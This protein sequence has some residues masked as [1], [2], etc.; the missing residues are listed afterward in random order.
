[1]RDSDKNAWWRAAEVLLGVAVVALP[2]ALGGAPW[3]TLFLL[4]PLSAAAVGVWSWGAFRKK[5][6]WSW[7]PVLLLP[8]ATVAMAALQLIPLPPGLLAVL[9]PPA[10]EVRDFALLPL[11]LE[12]W[13]PITLDAASTWRM[14]ARD[15]SLGGLLFVAVQLGRLGPSRERLLSIVGATAIGFA[16]IAVVHQLAG[17]DELFG[18]WNFRTANPLLTPFGNANHLAAFLTLGGTVCLG[19]ALS[20]PERESLVGWGLGA[21]GCG[22][23]VFLT[24][25]RGG[26]G[27]FL[28][29]WLLVAG[30]VLA[31]R[32]G[33]VKS[34]APWLIIGATIVGAGLLAWEQLLARADTISSVAKLQSSKLEEWP[35]FARAVAAGGRTGLGRGAFEV[36][37]SR[38][39]EFQMSVTFTH[40]ENLALQLGADFGVP[41]ALAL[42]GLAAW[43]LWRAFRGT[44][45]SALEGIAL[46]GVVG[47][48]L[49]DLFDFSLE[50]NALPVVAAVVLGLVA[51]MDDQQPRATVRLGESAV[52]SGLV[53]MGVGA[54]FLGFPTHLDDEGRLQQAIAAGKKAPELRALVV[55]LLRRHP[56]DYLLYAN[57]AQSSAVRG[58][59]QNALAWVNRWQ[60]LRPADPQAHVA[61]AHALLRLGRREQALLE[62]KTSFLFGDYSAV[63]QAVRVAA[64]KGDYERLFVESR[65]L[66]TYAVGTLGGLPNANAVA[67]GLVE[68]ALA[69]PPSDA[70]K[71]EAMEL[72]LS[73]EA[74]AGRASEALAL[75]DALPE[76][77]RSRPDMVVLKARLL[78]GSGRVEEG[79][80]VLAGVLT[81][82][83]G[84]AAAA[85]QLAELEAGRGQPQAALDVLAR[86]KPFVADPA[87]R[88]ALFTREAT[89]W[90]STGRWA[91]ALDGWQTASRLEPARADLH[92]RM[93]AA[94]ERMGSM[95]A[96]LDEVRAGR[97]L[98]TPEGAK[99]QDGWVN[100][101]D[102]QATNQMP[103]PSPSPEP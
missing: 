86:I 56:A 4:V 3:W 61:A 28:L 62:Y 27:S 15:L 96:A 35:M 12:A 60:F 14:L 51:G 16:I 74:N 11:G 33:G 32:V 85:F 76:D 10:A 83:P 5:R 13:R 103:V 9:A 46:L 67:Q 44:R 7:H 22:V 72:K 50:L 59:A 99:A 97:L 43:A 81:Q 36:A 38:W 45:G 66:L 102:A 6:R 2:V 71:W 70:V 77:V 65:G 48:G 30:L 82:D 73:S 25:S 58:D 101:L 69:E 53:A 98:D 91:R 20:A 41:G 80:V 100:R 75:L 39:H 87:Q 57:L 26:I 49:H 1:M 88:S 42:F 18:L 64:Q 79:V 23:T 34:A 29:T 90:E 93:A 63:P 55:P 94:Y 21:L 37:F 84:N 78:T 68:R 24:M 17:L 54:A 52:M 92:Y 8:L 19:L 89:L 95:H 40:P 47:L 31:R